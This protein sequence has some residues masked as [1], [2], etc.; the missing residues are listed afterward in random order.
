MLAVS[1]SI[2]NCPLEASQRMSLLRSVIYS[3]GGEGY[4]DT[5]VQFGILHA[6][7]NFAIAF[8]AEIL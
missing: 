3:Q 7:S 4:R 2:L 1:I 8:L 5:G 6:N